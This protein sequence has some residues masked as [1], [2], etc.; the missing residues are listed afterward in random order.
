MK[1][2][3]LIVANWKLNPTNGKTATMWFKKIQTQAL[4]NKKSVETV[5]C[6]PAVYLESLQSLVTDRTCV[7]GAQDCFWENSGSYTGEISPEMIFNAK[8]RYTIIGHS[9][10]RNLGETDKII[11]TKIAKIL[12]FPLFVILCVGEKIRTDN[13]DHFKEIK[14]QISEALIGITADQ[15]K[16]I[17]IAYEPVWAIGKDAVRTATV[18]ESFEMITVIRRIITELYS[19]ELG[20]EITVLY[21]GSTNAENIQEFLIIGGADG[22]LVGRASLDPKEFGSMINKASSI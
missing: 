12:Q 1:K 5:I 8:A 7:L 6:P 14:K 2:K 21:G 15:M 16:R 11:N 22:V 3:K 9:E 13:G 20:Q 19:V 17:V 18:D 4:K 10:R